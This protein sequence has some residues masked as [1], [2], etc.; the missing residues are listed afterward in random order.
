MALH[1]IVCSGLYWVFFLTL[2]FLGEII[3]GERHDYL[4]YNPSVASGYNVSQ[5][6][7]DDTIFECYGVGTGCWISWTFTNLVRLR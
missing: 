4:V 5:I 7:K 2:S 3:D 6:A 1:A